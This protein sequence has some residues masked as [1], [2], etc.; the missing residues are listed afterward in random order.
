MVRQRLSY[1][2]I[3]CLRLAVKGPNT[4]TLE[5]GISKGGDNADLQTSELLLFQLLSYRQLCTPESIR[6]HDIFPLDG[7]S[8]RDT[9]THRGGKHLLDSILPNDSLDRMGFSEKCMA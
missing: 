9:Q 7:L 4:G 1:H 8:R 2:G 5:P 6:V 3:G